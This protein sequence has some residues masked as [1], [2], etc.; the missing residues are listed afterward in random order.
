MKLIC[1]ALLALAA[2]SSHAGR[3]LATEDAGVLDPRACEVEGAHERER[4]AGASARVHS[5]QLACGVGARTQLALAASR[6][7]DGGSR[8]EGLRLGGKTR[9]WPTAAD[10]EAPAW[11]LAYALEAA[12]DGGGSW[13][14]AG[15]AVQLVHSRPAGESLTLHLNLGHERGVPAR[16]GRTTLGVA[17][18]HEGVA[19]WMPMAELYGDDRDAPWWSLGLRWVAL[20]ERL[21]FGLAWGRQIASGRPQRTALSFTFN[22]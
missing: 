16:Q 20:P 1:P 5:L 2:A 8:A 18:E 19:G 17:A 13:G 14:R 3:P 9:L 10:D 12:R 15:H 7:R 11:T 6:E 22:F 21:S 4:A